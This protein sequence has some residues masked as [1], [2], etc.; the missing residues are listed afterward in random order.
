M[1][2]GDWTQQ[3]RDRLAEHQ[4]AVPEGLWA[5]IESKLDASQAPRRAAFIA[6]KRWAA[7]AVVLLL[8]GGTLLLWNQEESNEALPQETIAK[9]IVSQQERIANNAEDEEQTPP[10][11]IASQ[12]RGLKHTSATSESIT[13]MPEQQTATSMPEQ[14]LATPE[15]KAATPERQATP[16]SPAQTAEAKETKPET[17]P[18]SPRIAPQP[19]RRSPQPTKQGRERQ[20]QRL[21]ASLYT[22]NGLDSWQNDQRV[23]MSTELANK[24]NSYA[25]NASRE[26]APIWLKDF[27]ER[28]RHHRPIAF[29]LKVGYPLSRRWTVSTG[30]VYT[31]LRSE[32]TNV[33][34][35]REIE[36]EQTLQYVGVPLSVQYQV[37]RY[38]RLGVYASAGGQ[39]DWNVSARQDTGNA[40][41]DIDKDRCQW[42]IN[43][44]LGL[45]YDITPHFGIYAEQSV[46]HYFDNHSLVQNYFKD[47]PT[48]FSLQ[49]GVRLTLGQAI[50]APRAQ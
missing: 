37:L 11:A 36:R 27:E 21:T 49:L 8:G 22:G 28:A 16:D 41:L 48:A 40:R 33:M 3:L 26:A 42:S 18:T 39:A 34:K 38:K 12:A 46:I 10:P 44:S 50:S 35:G 17:I 43:G 7:A 25:T 1:K 24:Y 6:W 23:Q 47:K 9:A 31:R 4:E 30:M 13:S 5:G 19:S 45:S 2:Q 14:Q 20:G 15:R 29:G 32:F